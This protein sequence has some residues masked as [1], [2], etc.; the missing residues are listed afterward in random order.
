MR[1]ST[2]LQTKCS[3]YY[4]NLN[5]ERE[6]IKIFQ[7]RKF[8]LR[9]CFFFFFFAKEFQRIYKSR[10]F[11]PKWFLPASSPSEIACKRW[12]PGK[13]C[14]DFCEIHRIAT[15]SANWGVCNKCRTFTDSKIIIVIISLFWDYYS[16][17][18]S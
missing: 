9:K 13:L 17:T 14:C 15:W 7:T 11:F 3:K 4:C 1:V 2:I 5:V 18:F 12:F 6:K 10:T 16:V 8:V